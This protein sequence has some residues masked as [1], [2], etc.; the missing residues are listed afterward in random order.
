MTVLDEY[1]AS[2]LLA[3]SGIPF[4]PFELTTTL[5]EA[6]DAAVR[7]GYPV[8]MKISSSEL[9][10]KT[11]YGGVITGIPD[12]E[13]CKDAWYRLMEN[14]GRAGLVYP[15]SLR[16]IMVQKMVSGGLEF[17]IGGKRDPVFGPVVMFGIG[18]IYAELFKETA[19]RLAPFD[20]TEAEK[21]V[22]STKAAALMDGFRGAGPAAGKLLYETLAEISLLMDRR[23]DI[24]ELDIN[25][26]LLGEK[27]GFALDG[28]IYLS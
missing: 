21:M 4:A 14:A 28:L 11:E 6:R 25:P 26:F 22:R 12:E 27:T 10:H 3:E 19:F 17:I 2:K 20:S 23:T 16:G 24:T 7:I 18:G 15:E 5:E 8:V 9:T 1:P 13:G